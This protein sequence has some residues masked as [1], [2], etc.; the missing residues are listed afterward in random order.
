MCKEIRL[1]VLDSFFSTSSGDV[2][3]NLPYSTWDFSTCLIRQS[4]MEMT[5]PQL[6]TRITLSTH[7]IGLHIV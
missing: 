6:C 4:T 5:M 2:K 3:K 7:L 1:L